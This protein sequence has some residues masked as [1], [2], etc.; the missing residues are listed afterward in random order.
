MSVTVLV[1]GVYHKKC[2][3]VGFLLHRAIQYIRIK[4]APDLD[5]S[6]HFKMASVVSSLNG[7]IFFI[8]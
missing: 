6:L 2:L 1:F 4:H 5:I 8:H 7:F 3:R